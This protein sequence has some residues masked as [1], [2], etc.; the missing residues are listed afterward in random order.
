[1]ATR[2]PAIVSK[3]MSAIHGK[4]TGIEKKLR[5]ALTARGLRYSTCSKKVIG[6]PDILFLSLRIAIF[7]DSEFWHGYRFE[8]NQSKIHTNESYWIP[9]IKR[10]IARDEEVNEAL[11]E[12][13]FLVLRYWG[14]EIEKR[15]E[16]IAEQIAAIVKR[17][18]KAFSDARHVEEL[19]TLVYVE[20][21]DS[22]L[23]LHRI[24]EEGDVNAGKWIGLGGHLEEGETPLDCVKR[25]IKEESGLLVKKARYLGKI[26]FLNAKYPTERMY[27]YKVT[28]FEGEVGECDEGVLEFVEKERMYSLP[29]WEG[30]RAFLPY[31]EEN[32]PPFYML[33]TYEGDRLTDIIGPIWKRG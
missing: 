17:R 5:K 15:S 24:K 13:G 18:K 16:E 8:E 21:G 30:D 7:C 3:T 14:F 1:M 2:D 28:S 11:K 33:L 4:D 9:K 31:L 19:T 6:H 12:Q 23:L 22:Y 27:L 10:N 25:E 32:K 20:K 26:D 29:M